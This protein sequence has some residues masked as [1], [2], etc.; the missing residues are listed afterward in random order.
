MTEVAERSVRLPRQAVVPLLLGVL[1]SFAPA[2]AISQTPRF[3]E[4]HTWTDVATIYEFNDR[5]RYD[6]DYGVRGLF[7]D[8]D[9][10]QLY[11]RPSVRYQARPWLLL[12]GGA[13]LFYSFFSG[14]D[15]PEIR[16]WVGVR[17][18]GPRPGGWA[19]S[20]YFRLEYRAFYLKSSNEWDASFRGRWQLQ[21]TS[22]RFRIGSAREFYGLASIE[23]F[24]EIGSSIEGTFGDRFRIN[25]GLGRQFTEALRI[26][27]DYLFHVIRLPD[28][29]G[30]LDLND[31]VLRLRFF[32][33]FKKKA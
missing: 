24:Q 4:F 22:P 5:F 23:V 25:A 29:G 30:D 12:H 3:E 10:T 20:N 31:H 7:T 26:E 21:A 32:Y 14:E 16:P 1:M 33:R 13:G 27:L 8:S 11:L 6:G 2:P 9:W 18:L 15:L 19:I 17:F 28:E